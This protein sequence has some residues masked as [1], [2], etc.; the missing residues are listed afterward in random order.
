M[1]W[2]REFQDRAPEE[3]CAFLAL[4]TV[5]AGG[6][7]SRGALEQEDVRVDDRAQRR[8]GRGR[9]GRR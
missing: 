3:F 1:R 9:A 7:L 4:Q 2:Y 6:A 8:A 5:A